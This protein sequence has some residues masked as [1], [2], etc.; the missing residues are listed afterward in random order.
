MGKADAWMPLY[1]ADYQADTTRLTLELSGAYLGLLMDYWRNGPP[2]DDDAVLA[3][4]LS[5]KPLHFRR[6]IRPFL[7]S[8][9]VISDGRWT[10]KR[11]ESEL[12]R[13]AENSATA[14]ARA[15]KAAAARWGKT[16]SK[17]MLG[18]MLEQCPSPSPSSVLTEQAASAMPDPAKECWSRGVALLVRAGRMRENPARTFFGKLLKTHGVEARDLLPAVVRAEGVGTQDPQSYLTA[19]ARAL[20]AKRGGASKSEGWTAWTDDEWTVA[21]AGFRA[22]GDWLPGVP[23]PGEAG[24]PAPAALLEAA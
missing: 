6:K 19:A 5:I 13:A 20:A 24:C 1:I 11:V 8:F 7:L 2:P 10:H 18:A 22:N 3:R 14:R 4:I 21:L 9:F 15:S 12:A 17:P 16:P 23:K